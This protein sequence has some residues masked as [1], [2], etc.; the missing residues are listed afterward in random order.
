MGLPRP[1]LVI[2]DAEA[3]TSKL[4]GSDLPP[5]YEDVADIP[6]MYDEATMKPNAH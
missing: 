2:M 4:P 3:G 6:P 5:K 1:S